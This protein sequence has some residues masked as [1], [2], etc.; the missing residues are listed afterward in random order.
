MSG[1]ARPLPGQLTLVRSVRRSLAQATPKGNPMSPRLKGERRTFVSPQDL[2][3]T[4]HGSLSKE[5]REQ[6][7]RMMR[8]DVAFTTLCSSTLELGIDIG[9]VEVVGQIGAPW[10]VSSLIQRLGRSGR[11]GDDASEMRIFIECMPLHNDSSLLDRLRPDLL[12]G[13][14]LTELMLEKWL[15]PPVISS[16]DVS[17]FIQQTLSVLAETGG[18]SAGE[19][20]TRLIERSAFRGME[21][22]QFVYLL[23]GL[24]EQNLVEQ[25]SEI[26]SL[27]SRAN[28]LSNRWTSTASS[29]QARSLR[30]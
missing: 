1:G 27:E 8:G 4:H 5:I 18:V 30:Y 16:F 26:S 20:F 7:E 23:R 28:G 11:R 2:Q 17:T 29:H 14:A 13:I 12:Q 22:K 25:V 21:K 19:L 9:N 15:E 6:T 10:S 3:K 24:G